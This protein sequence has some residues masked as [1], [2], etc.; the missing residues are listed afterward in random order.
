M[1]FYT[2]IELN[3]EVEMKMH[4]DFRV[5]WDHFPHRKIWALN[6]KDN[7]PKDPAK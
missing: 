1:Q 5:I 3:E 4:D 7:G 6:A 2:H